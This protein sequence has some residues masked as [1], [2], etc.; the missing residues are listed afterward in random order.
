MLQGSGHD[1]LGPAR[2]FFLVFAARMLPC[3]AVLASL[4]SFGGA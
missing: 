4:F 3:L 2:G 1:M